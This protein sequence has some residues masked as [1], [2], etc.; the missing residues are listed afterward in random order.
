M[1]TRSA[2][3]RVSEV[4][5]ELFAL[6]STETMDGNA[7]LSKKLH[8]AYHHY[9]KVQHIESFLFFIMLCY[10]FI[11]YSYLSTSHLFFFL[12]QF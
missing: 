2:V 8:Q 9:I 6:K 3:R 7:Y 5:D 10:F 12:Y 4:P 11:I 1:L